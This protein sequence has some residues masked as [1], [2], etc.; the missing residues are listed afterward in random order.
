MNEIQNMK[1]N[2]YYELVRQSKRR[3]SR[4]L[5]RWIKCN[6]FIGSDSPGEKIKGILMHN[7]ITLVRFSKAMNMSLSA[8]H[9]LVSGQSKITTE[10]AVRL[11]YVI[12]ENPEYWLQMQYEY[13]LLKIKVDK[14]SLS[15]LPILIFNYTKIDIT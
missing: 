4:S 7:K 5:A 3:V 8:C 2:Y 14:K 15:K 12:G 11:S 6:E 13:E 9:Y 1:N 10:K